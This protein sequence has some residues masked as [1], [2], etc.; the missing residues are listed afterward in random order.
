MGLEGLR[1]EV[2]QWESRGKSRYGDNVPQK[3]KQNVKL[4]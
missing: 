4:L 1:T 3:M 2:F